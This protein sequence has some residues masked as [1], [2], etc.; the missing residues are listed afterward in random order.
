MVWIDNNIPTEV[1]DQLHRQEMIGP[2]ERY[3]RLRVRGRF[4]HGEEY[5]H[6]GGFTAQIV[7]LEVEL[8]AWAPV[9]QPGYSITDLKYRLIQHLGVVLV[10]EPVG[11][12]DVIRKEQALNALAAIQQNEEEFQAILDY[13]GLERGSEFTEDQQV[14]VLRRRRN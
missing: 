7:P 6:L 10:A 1:Y 13:L 4:E 2:L 3:G 5:G 9:Q 11:V 12:P 14:Q 8:L